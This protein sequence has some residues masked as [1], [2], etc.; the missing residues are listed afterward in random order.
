MRKILLGLL[1]AAGAGLGVA[2][3]DA[4]TRILYQT[5]SQTYIVGRT[6]ESYAGIWVTA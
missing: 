4:C 6:M 1:A 3:A 5:G 2:Q